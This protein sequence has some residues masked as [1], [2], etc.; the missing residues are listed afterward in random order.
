MGYELFEMKAYIQ[1]DWKVLRMPQPF[2]NDQWGLYNLKEDPGE[3]YDVSDQ[4]PEKKAE[5][6]ASYEEYV[7]RNE[8]FDHNGHFDSLYRIAY[9]IE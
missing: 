7:L 6:I 8:V 9:G 1:G 4:Y 2:G 5:L 3:L